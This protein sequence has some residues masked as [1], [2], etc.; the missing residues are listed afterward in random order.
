MG[1][2]AEKPSPP[3]GL[4]QGDGRAGMAGAVPPRYRMPGEHP[5]A[6]GGRAVRG[7]R[8][9]VDVLL[10]A[11]FVALMA[12][13]TVQEF[14]HEWLGISAFVLFVV[15]Q[16][17]NRRWWAGL[18]RGRYTPL[19]AV[20]TAV[21][22]GL[23][24]CLVGLMASSLVL[25]E[26]AFGWLPALPGAAW[27]RVAHLLCSYWGFVL[28]FAHAGLCMRRYLAPRP[29]RGHAGAGRTAPGGQAVRPA[30]AG[31]WVARLCAVAAVLAGAW[32]FAQLNMGTYLTLQSQ[33]LFADPSVPL[34]LT[35]AEYALAG[36]GIACTAYAL[37][38][39][40][41]ALAAAGGSRTMSVPRGKDHTA[42]SRNART[43]QDS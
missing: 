5:A 39:A 17:L 35:L 38:A 42:P 27:A 11:V 29:R 36:A 2:R 14:A 24:V 22:L 16:V 28:A 9:V 3:R 1:G 21:N 7:V 26:H 6:K 33:F 19:R 15:H 43:R 30:G 4:R 10:A 40:L 18:L 37:G 34:A 12:T 13:A 23:L 31:R 32:S 20:G 25:S 8:L 41:R